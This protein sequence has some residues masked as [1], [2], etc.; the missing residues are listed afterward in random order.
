MSECE[1][2]KVNQLSISLFCM[3]TVVDHCEVRLSVWSISGKE[4][5]RTA[6]LLLRSLKYPELDKR[7]CILHFGHRQYSSSFVASILEKRLWI[8]KIPYKP[9][10]R[11]HNHP[12]LIKDKV[13]NVTWPRGRTFTRIQDAAYFLT[14]NMRLLAVRCAKVRS[15]LAHLI[16]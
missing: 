13:W 7:C 14:G 16:L 4:P 9:L 2:T 11:R 3:Q 8:T 12:V 10:K 5:A 6:Y 15:R 1:S